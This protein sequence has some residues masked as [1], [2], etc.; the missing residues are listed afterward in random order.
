MPKAA[1]SLAKMVAMVN[2]INCLTW[3]SSSCAFYLAT[4]LEQK[5]R[6]KE[7]IDETFPIKVSDKEKFSLFVE[8]C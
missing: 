8:Y 7:L 5:T 6:K 4:I 1:V 2:L 3:S